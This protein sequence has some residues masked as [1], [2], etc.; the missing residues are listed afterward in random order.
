VSDL[1]PWLEMEL[2]RQLSPV[3]APAS[4]SWTAIEARRTERRMATG[5][6]VLWPAVAL[7][8]LFACG[9]LFRNMRDI[10]QLTG[11]ELRSIAD[12]PQACDFW[13]N[14]PAEIRNW[15]KSKGNIDV[16]IPPGRSSAV[17]LIGARLAHVRGKLVAAIEYQVGNSTATLVVSRH[18]QNEIASAGGD[19]QGACL[20]CHL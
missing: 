16:E 9:A 2:A 15:V 11:Q 14:D 1:R 13:S 3:A 20:L 6:W 18:G 4:L 19:S 8:L 17:R 5:G 10:T 12:S 7:M